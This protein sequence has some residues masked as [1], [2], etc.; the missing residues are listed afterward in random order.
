MLKRPCNLFKKNRPH[1][2]RT[3]L[4]LLQQPCTDV[5]IELF[6]TPSTMNYNPARLQYFV[7]NH[8]KTM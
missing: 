8:K 2:I 4:N 1:K 5:V 3:S 7:K 6:L